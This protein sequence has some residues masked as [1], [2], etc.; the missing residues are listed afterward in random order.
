MPVWLPPGR[1]EISLA[2]RGDQHL[3]IP[4]R[5]FEGQSADFAV[6]PVAENEW[7]MV[8]P[9]E[10]SE[11]RMLRLEGTAGDELFEPFAAD[12]EITWDPVERT[13]ET[14]ELLRGG[15]RAVGGGTEQSGVD[16]E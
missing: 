6:T 10:V 16:R 5:L 3:R 4:V 8:A 13:L 9:L 12:V 7:T 2:V 14:A 15:L 11:G 1:Y